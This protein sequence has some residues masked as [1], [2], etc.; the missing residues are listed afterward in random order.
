MS[1]HSVEVQIEQSVDV[2]VLVECS[3]CGASDLD[4]EVDSLGDNEITVEVHPCECMAE[5]DGV[6]AICQECDTELEVADAYL[7][8]RYMEI[9]V[10][11]CD[12][13]LKEPEWDKL[14]RA[15]AEELAEK[16]FERLGVI[17]MEEAKKKAAAKKAA[18]KKA[19]AKKGGK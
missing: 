7:D 2:A 11:R 16:A 19:A 15:Q 4:C 8:G 5:P 17:E 12:H 1:S 9:Q 6:R 14:T 13:C 10:G 18:T 3:N